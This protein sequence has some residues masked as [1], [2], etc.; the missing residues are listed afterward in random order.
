M[1]V[2]VLGVIIVLSIAIKT[3]RTHRSSSSAGSAIVWYFTMVS[4]T[5]VG[6]SL[7]LFGSISSGKS[8]VATAVSACFAKPSAIIGG[9]PPSLGKSRTHL[10]ACSVT[11]MLLAPPTS[12]VMSSGLNLS[13]SHVKKSR[14]CSQTE[15]AFKTHCLYS[16]SH[17]ICKALLNEGVKK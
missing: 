17:V 12:I 2:D 5:L 6:W 14:S 11:S 13:M 8:Q 4:A 7:T 1:Y 10:I 15:D 9:S 3:R 16:C